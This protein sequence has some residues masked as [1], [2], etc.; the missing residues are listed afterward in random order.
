MFDVQQV[1]RH[2]FSF[3]AGVNRNYIV[4]EKQAHK[5]VRKKKNVENIW[6]IGKNHETGKRC[7]G[8]RD[9]AN[10]LPF[11]AFSLHVRAVIQDEPWKWCPLLIIRFLSFSSALCSSCP[12]WQKGTKTG[13]ENHAFHWA[14]TMG[15]EPCTVG[16][17]M[18][19]EEGENAAARRKCSLCSAL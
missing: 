18:Y 9:R 4:L 19:A 2:H 5:D 12:H 3:Q 6:Q 8:A 15:R 7:D 14:T 16:H 10:S 1:Q 17:C 11:W 13:P